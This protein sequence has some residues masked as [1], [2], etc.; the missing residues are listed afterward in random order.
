MEQK[1]KTSKEISD[2]IRKGSKFVYYDG[3]NYSASTAESRVKRE[4]LEYNIVTSVITKGDYHLLEAV[5]S[6]GFATPE[7]LLHRLRDGAR[8]N[9]ESSI[10]IAREGRIT[11]HRTMRGRL[12]FLTRQGL[13]HCCEYIDNYDN[14]N[15]I[16]ACSSEG[17]RAFSNAL[18]CWVQYNKDMVYKP[19]YEVFRYLAANTVAY[20]L[21]LHPNC[22]KILPYGKFSYQ[23]NGREQSEY[24]YGR[25]EYQTQEE[26]KINYILEP[27]VFSVN[28]R[29]ISLE[30]NER[31]LQ[32]RIVS[33]RNAV[34]A[35][36]SQGEESYIIFI[37]ENGDG[38][39]RLKELI[40]EYELDFFLDRCLFTCENIISSTYV[41]RGGAATDCLL[42]MYLNNGQIRFKQR[43]MEV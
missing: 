10:C 35:L 29:I 14:V 28:T 3:I 43:D 40:L 17:F 20:V 41:E 42:C 8:R 13:L 33:L 22:T 9:E 11:N 23:C 30:E 31:R 4:T 26:K 21:G 36:C 18:D 7:A 27:V 34:Q 25:L 24:L 5:H 39:T 1:K 19:P 2:V 38:L 37:V 15:Y 6:L 12:E 32:R 16:Y